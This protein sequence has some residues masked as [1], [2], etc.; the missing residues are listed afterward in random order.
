MADQAVRLVLG[1]D[2]DTADAGIDRVRQRE[3]DDARFAAE[4]D[5]GLGA[6]VGQL[7]QPAAASPCQHEGERV[8]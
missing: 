7:Q 4:I 2:R 6:A 5:R 8:A 1:G 3:I